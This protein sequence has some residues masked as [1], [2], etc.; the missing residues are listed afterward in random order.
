MVSVYFSDYAAFL[1]DFFA[2]QCNFC[3]NEI[4]FDSNLAKQNQKATK[5]KKKKISKFG[6]F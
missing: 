3:P 5:I 6:K 4:C 2:P 1:F